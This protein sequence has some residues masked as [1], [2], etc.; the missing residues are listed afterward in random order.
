M[1][2]LKKIQLQ[3]ILYTTQKKYYNYLIGHN[4]RLDEIQAAMLRIKLKRLDEYINQTKKK[5]LSFYYRK[6]KKNSGKYITPIEENNNL[7]AYH[8]YIYCRRKIEKR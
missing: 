4:S 6:I 8:Q 1:H 5:M 2:R 3:T 7:H